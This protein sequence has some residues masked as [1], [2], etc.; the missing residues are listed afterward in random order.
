M[1]V[2]LNAAFQISLALKSRL[3]WGAGGDVIV[4]DEECDGG[5]D[6]GDYCEEGEAGQVMGDRDDYERDPDRPEDPEEQPSGENQRAKIGRA[7]C[8]E[9]V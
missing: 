4:D 5:Q 2:K 3:R 7:S 6:Y 1:V 8:R 9:R